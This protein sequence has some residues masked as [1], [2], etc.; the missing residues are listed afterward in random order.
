MLDLVLA[1]VHHVLIFGIFGIVVAEFMAVR[2]GMSNAAAVR[3]ASIDLWYGVNSRPC[4][5]SSST[6][7]GLRV[8]HSTAS[9]SPCCAGR[10]PAR[11]DT[12]GR[13]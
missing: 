9:V 7:E 13:V 6:N 4:P 8:P 10:P 12:I 2:P 3:I 1:I 5:H 11:A